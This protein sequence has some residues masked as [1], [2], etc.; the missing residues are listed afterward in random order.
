MN[1]EN[2]VPEYIDWFNHRHLYGVIDMISLV[3]YGQQLGIP[4]A[5]GHRKPVLVE[6]RTN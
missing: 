1:T 5:Q 6:V 2:T 3:E 4:D